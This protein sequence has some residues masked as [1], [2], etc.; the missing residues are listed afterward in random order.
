MKLWH[1]I[2]TT[3]ALTSVAALAL[4]E[5]AALPETRQKIS[6]VHPPVIANPDLWI[7]DPVKMIMAGDQTGTPPDSPTAR[8]DPN[9]STSPYSGVCQLTLGGGALCTGVPISRFHILTAGHCVDFNDNGTNDIG[10]NIIIR[11]N[12]SGN[13]STIIGSGA[14][15]SVT[16][17]PDFTGFNNP[18]V[19]DDLTIITLNQPIPNFIPIY[20]VFTGAVTNGELI[21]PVGY[22]RSGFGDV[23]DTVGASQNNKRVGQN[24][25]EQFFNDEEGS[26]ALEV[27]EYDFD[28]PTNSTNCFGSGSLGNDIETAVAGGDSG[29][30]SFVTVNNRL[31]TWGT[32]TFGA[33]CIGP[34]PTFGSVGGGIVLSGYIG[35]IAS[36]VP[37]S[38]FDLIEPADGAVGVVVAPF[39]D[40]DRPDFTGTYRITIAT[41][42]A[43][44][45]ILFSQDGIGASSSQFQMPAGVLAGNTQYFWSVSAINA[46]GETEADDAPFAMTTV[47]NADLNADGSVNGADLAILLIAWNTDG[48]V[49][50]SD[51]NGDGIVNGSDLAMLLIGWTG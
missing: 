47:T 50:G 22:G 26:G 16:V 48:G 20:P 32:N 43:M 9:I 51:L 7:L 6:K 45:N 8:I 35:W 33:N 27:F 19:N 42:Q 31:M 3:A 1:T 4:A 34:T 36:F 39:F 21:T 28:G 15:S 37:P 13:G 49:T 25:A 44:N 30:P 41:D 17:N 14:I 23:G 12:Y 46:N 11:F 18:T 5:D 38:P 24:R 40:W 10:T 29:G 2:I